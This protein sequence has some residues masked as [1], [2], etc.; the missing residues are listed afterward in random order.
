MMIYRPASSE[1]VERE[2]LR[3]HL[4]CNRFRM[5]ANKNKNNVI[6]VTGATGH[7]GGSS[8]RHLRER[9]FGCRALTRDPAK[10]QARALIGPGVEVVRGDLDDPAS[11]T[12]AL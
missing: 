7:Q 8:L 10:P 5:P 11:L 1:S 4:P 2:L 3:W 9:G 6:L 12:R